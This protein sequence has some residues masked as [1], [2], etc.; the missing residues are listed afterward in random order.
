[1]QF[2]LENIKDWLSL[3]ASSVVYACIRQWNKAFFSSEKCIDKV[4]DEKQ[5]DETFPLLEKFIQEEKNDP[6]MNMILIF[7]MKELM[8]MEV[9]LLVSKNNIVK[10]QEG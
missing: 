9:E 10:I 4:K 7:G 2:G 1:M 8:G 3:N 5:E 6:E